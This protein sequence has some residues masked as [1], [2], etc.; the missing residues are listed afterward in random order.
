MVTLVLWRADTKCQSLRSKRQLDLSNPEMP[1]TV[2]VCE[3]MKKMLEVT[4]GRL[5]SR[6][7]NTYRSVVIKDRYPWISV[8]VIIEHTE[9]GLAVTRF[10]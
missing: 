3:A 9:H 1:K 7:T 4:D 8:Q 6:S 10:C 2:R 5:S